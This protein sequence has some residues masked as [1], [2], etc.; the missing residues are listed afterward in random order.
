M[1]KDAIQRIREA[2]DQAAV[3][4]RVAGER[5]ADMRRRIHAQGEA[6]CAEVE[7]DT[8][9]EY[10]A[11][12]EE[13]RQRALALE[14]KKCAEAEAEAAAIEAAAREKIEEAINIIVWEIVERCQ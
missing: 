13:V 8:E 7:R 3:L 1:S 6:H 5:A 11:R 2:E 10:A 14:E 9:A 12:L 4:C